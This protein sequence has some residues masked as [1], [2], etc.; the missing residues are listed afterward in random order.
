[1]L[2][3]IHSHSVLIGGAALFL[4][5]NVSGPLPMLCDED[6]LEVADHIQLDGG[7]GTVCME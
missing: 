4:A 6:S 3:E 2:N 1:M 5:E 7:E